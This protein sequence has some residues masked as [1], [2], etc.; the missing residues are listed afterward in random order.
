MFKI[1]NHVVFNSLPCSITRMT[2]D[3]NNYSIEFKGKNQFIRVTPTEYNEKSYTWIKNFTS[4]IQEM[5]E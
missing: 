2:I 5:P 3:G 1:T 4:E